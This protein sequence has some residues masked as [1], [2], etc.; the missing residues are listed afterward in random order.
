ME[1]YQD[2]GFLIFGSRLRRMSEYYI[3]EVNKVYKDQDIEFEAS[4]FPVFYFLYHQE[5]VNMRNIAD[6]LQVSHSAISQLVKNL[7]KKGLVDTRPYDKD[8]RQLI[9][10]LTEKG[11][12][13]MRQ[14]QPIWDSIAESMNS[15]KESVPAT[16][17]LLDAFNALEMFFDETTLSSVILKNLK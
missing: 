13:L 14:T 17:Y 6:Q 15:I 9:V 11:D 4:W 16:E 2:L 8:R 3:A 7:R 5:E 12:E 1:I 10:E